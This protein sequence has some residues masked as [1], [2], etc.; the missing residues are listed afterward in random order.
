MPTVTPGFEPRVFRNST[1][2][3]PVMVEG[4]LTLETPV[5]GSIDDDHPAVVY[6][7]QATAG[8]VIDAR[9]SKVS[10]NLDPFLVI[11]DPKGRE[12]ARND[13]VEGEGDDVRDSAIH[14]VTLAE[15]GQYAFVATR[16]GQAFGTTSGDFELVMGVSSRGAAGTF[17][18]P[19]GY[20]TSINAT[21]DDE[22]PERIYT[23]R[24]AAGDIITIQMTTTSG[25]LDPNIT[26]TDNTGTVLAQND[27]NLV[28]GVFDSIIQSY[29][30]PRTGYYSVIARRYSSVENSGDFRLKIA[31]EGQTANRRFA[32]LNTI[33][34]GIVSEEGTLY[35]SY[36]L[37]D[38]IDDEDGREHSYQGLLTFELPPADAPTIE[39][40]TFSIAPCYERGGGWD[41]LGA[42]TTY[43]DNYG[44]ITETR[45]ITRPLPGARIL[46][47]QTDCTPLD[48]TELVQNAYDTGETDIQLRLI[49]RDRENNGETD[50]VLTTPSLVITFAQ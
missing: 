32:L 40:A 23:F 41:T 18:T 14:I 27:D 17:S 39:N 44:V 9:L 36:S 13:D 7:Y 8:E 21:L 35:S 26:L 20:E 15:S 29:I 16:F 31:R 5:N 43:V 48:V 50:M 28:M 42:L 10:G 12:I 25:D 45:N 33:N 37:G 1:A 11:L 19:T 38:E 6:T 3:Q 47:T 46:N 30:L 4:E 49:F 2:S 24:G 34:S 22:T